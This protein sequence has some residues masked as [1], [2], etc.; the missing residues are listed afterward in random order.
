MRKNRKGFTLIE[1]LIVMAVLAILI[2]IAV[3]AFRGMQDSAKTTKAEGDLKLIKMALE[4]YYISNN[5]FPAD[6]SS[7]LTAS[8][9]ILDKELSDPFEAA[10]TEYN[11]N[12]D[13]NNKYY[14]VSSTGKDGDPELDSVNLTIPISGELQSF[15]PGDDIYVTNVTLP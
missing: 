5:V 4:S 11:Y 14:M 8:P 6:L 12:L 10:G 1:L 9:K 13:T 3:P 7:L 15:S 2:G